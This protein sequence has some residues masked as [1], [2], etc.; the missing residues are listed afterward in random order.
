MFNFWTATDS[1]P[2]KSAQFC[3]LVSSASVIMLHQMIL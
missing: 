3:W 2:V 1:P